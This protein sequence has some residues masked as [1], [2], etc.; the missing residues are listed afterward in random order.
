MNGGGD[1]AQALKNE[2]TLERG[3]V[4]ATQDAAL[5]PR[6][7]ES[8]FLRWISVRQKVFLPLAMGLALLGL[9]ELIHRSG[10]VSAVLAP[11]PLTVGEV[12]IR[13]GSSSLLWKEMW[14]TV[15]EGLLGFAIGASSGFI[16]GMG[17][18]L[19]RVISRGLYPYVIL[20]QAM[21]RVAL[22]PIFI[23][24]LGFGMGSKILT[25]AV[26]CFFPVMIN[27]IVGLQSADEAS[28]SLMRSLCASRWQIFRKLLFPGAL[29]MIFAGL[30]TS[31]TLA[32]VGAIV[33][34]LAAANAGIGL[35]I[36]SSSFQLR[37]ASVFGYILW[38]SIVTLGIFGIV[39][40]L[41][42]RVV[43]WRRDPTSK[44]ALDDEWQ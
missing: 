2:S 32:F 35:L 23:A 16:L 41:D 29:P 21:P 40:F 24:L 37:I 15:Q 26:I 3:D 13:Q 22:A 17:I 20:L 9:L 18:G 5:Q 4:H 6:A 44:A 25:A 33:G 36:E 19:S 7:Q 12:M 30:K 42:R 31:I 11:S 28:L 1:Q 27:A 39:E 38:L 10:L 34:E 43:F 14:V 8:L